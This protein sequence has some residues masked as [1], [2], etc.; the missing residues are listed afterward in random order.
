MPFHNDNNNNNNNTST[1]HRPI[2]FLSIP[3]SKDAVACANTHRSV[4]AISSH[5]RATPSGRTTTMLCIARVSSDHHILPP[6]P[7]VLPPSPF[8]GLFGV[9]PP[10]LELLPCPPPDADVGLRTPPPADEGRLPEL[11]RGRGTWTCRPDLTWREL[12]AALLLW[13]CL[14]PPLVLPLLLPP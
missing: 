8:T 4:T 7:P 5:H 13:S 9:R 14:L 1:P 6:N 3:L 10:E 11:L 2:P 12:P